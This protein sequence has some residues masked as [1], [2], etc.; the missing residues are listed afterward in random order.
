MQFGD[1]EL[2]EF[3]STLVAFILVLHSKTEYHELSSK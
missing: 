3:F 2:E 1:L